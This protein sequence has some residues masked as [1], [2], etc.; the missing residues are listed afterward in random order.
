[1]LKRE[2]KRFWPG[3]VYPTHVELYTTQREVE[4]FIPN[5]GAVGIDMSVARFATLSDGTFIST[6]H[7][8]KRH[9]STLRKAQQAMGRKVKF[10]SN[11]KKAKTTEY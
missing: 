8:F 2:S 5:G 4:P 6:T 11:W 7:S 3:N 9:E 1:M 10:S